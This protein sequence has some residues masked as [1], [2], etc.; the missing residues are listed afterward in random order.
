MTVVAHP[1]AA[2]A[3]AIGAAILGAFRF[4][5]L[6]RRGRTVGAPAPATAEREA[7]VR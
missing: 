1:M 3:G 4:D 5:Q 7:G 2:L 6:E